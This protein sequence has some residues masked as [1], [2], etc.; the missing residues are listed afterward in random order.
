ML[1]AK[2]GSVGVACSF[3]VGDG[4]RTTVQSTEGGAD[5]RQS[6]CQVRAYLWRPRLVNGEALQA[7]LDSPLEVSAFGRVRSTE[8]APL[9]RRE[10]VIDRSLSRLWR[11]L[12]AW[13][14]LLRRID[15]ALRRRDRGPRVSDGLT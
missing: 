9:L 11:E 14:T 3:E 10:D 5:V 1:F 6:G 13:P 2:Q 4:F 8:K 15:Q 7:V 12:C